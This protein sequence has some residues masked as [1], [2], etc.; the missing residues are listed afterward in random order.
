LTK[1]LNAKTPVYPY[2]WND[3]SPLARVPKRFVQ[4]LDLYPAK[5]TR[6]ELNDSI[7]ETLQL[8][9]QETRRLQ[10]AIDRF[11]KDCHAIQA[12]K[13]RPIEP[14]EVGSNGRP[15]EEIR[16]FAVE[17]LGSQYS[18]LRQALLADSQNILGQQRFELFEKALDGFL[19]SDPDT[20]NLNS[21]FAI[22]PA[23]CKLAF[24]K[25][26]PGA[27]NIMWEIMASRNQGQM[28]TEY[29]IEEIPDYMRS[30]L[31][32]WIDIAQSPAEG[33]KL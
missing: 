30:R 26:K 1:R 18:D 12:Q 29:S 17:S 20:A 11:L 15:P 8:T 21:A 10:D 32:D 13:T 16:A 2:Q 14:S 19:P 27:R 28:I 33:G 4:M 31:Q 25:P 5:D 22:Y 24:F 7:K 23:S 6:G 3:N 9:D